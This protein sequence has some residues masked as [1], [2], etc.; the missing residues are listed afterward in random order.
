[1]RM[2]PL[3][4][5]LFSSDSETFGM[6]RVTSSGP[7]LVSR[8]SISN[9]SM[10]IEVYMSSLHQALADQDG[11]FEVVAAPGHE[12]HEHVAAQGQLAHVRAGAVGQDLAL[13]HVLPDLDDRLLVDAGVLV[14]ALELRQVVDVGADLLA[15]VGAVLGLDADDDAAA[16]HGVDHARAPADHRRARVLDRD[17]LHARAHQGR[18]RAQQG[19]GLALHVGAHQRAVG[20]VVLQER[21]ERGGH[22]HELLGAHVDVVDLVALG[23]DEV[24]GL[25]GRR[26]GPRRWRR[27]RRA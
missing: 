23:Q 26:R 27:R 18:F 5:R 14:R 19:H 1:M 21:D 24:A 2:I 12:G 22:R 9:S 6:S 25:C 7:S 15:L 4:S 11:V 17:V 16:V 8:A 3:S 20:V 13:G 10:W